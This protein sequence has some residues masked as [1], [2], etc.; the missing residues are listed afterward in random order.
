[1]P[2]ATMV[3]CQESTDM[4]IRVLIRMTTLERM[5][6][7]VLVTTT[8][9]PATSFATRLCISPVFWEVKNPSDN[10]WR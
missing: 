5:V 3:N 4:A 7:T 9:M 6:L 1:M 10:D 2:T 8:R